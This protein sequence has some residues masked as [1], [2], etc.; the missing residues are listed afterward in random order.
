MAGTVRRDRIVQAG[1]RHSTHE[2]DPGDGRPDDAAQCGARERGR[3]D[4]GSGLHQDVHW[5]GIDECDVAGGI[6][7][8]ARDPGV[9]AGNWHG[10]WLQTGGRDPNGQAVD[11]GDGHVDESDQTL[12]DVSVPPLSPGTYRVFWSVVARDG[13]RTQGDYT[14][15]LH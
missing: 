12:L 14:F 5:Q 11:R 6:C 2:S 10:G 13:H 8:D 15:T 9:C 3:N 4:G 1:L 7:H